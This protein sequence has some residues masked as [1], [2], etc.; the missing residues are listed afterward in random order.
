MMGLPILPAGLDLIHHVTDVDLGLPYG[1]TKHVIMMWVSAALCLLLFVPLARGRGRVP[2]GIWNF[3]EMVLVFLRDEMVR[4]TI[5]RDGDR[6][7]PVVWTFFFFI[8]FCNLLG[9]V[10][11]LATAT[12]NIGVTGALAVSA[13]AIFHVAGM[14]RQGPYTYL[15]NQVPPGLPI[16][17][18]PLMV[19]VEVI[20]HLV[21]PFA[22]CVR[23][24]ANMTAGHLVMAAILGLPLVFGTVWVAPVSIAVA[25]GLN[26]LELLVAV[27]QAYIF[28][29]LFTVFLGGALHPHH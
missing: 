23:L 4:P 25:V 3:L 18:L 28:T 9:L 21:K 24:F 10:P 2:S 7:L 26:L 12:G 15:K 14:V 20:G 22:L 19:A 1:I 29:L 8:L 27:I 5:G 11:G 13:F 17:L 16:V 6:F